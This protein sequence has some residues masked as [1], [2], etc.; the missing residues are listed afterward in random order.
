MLLQ[1]AE[2]DVRK[3]TYVSP[4]RNNVAVGGVLVTSVICRCFLR[5]LPLR[6]MVL[7]YSSYAA[8]HTACF[9]STAVQVVGGT[10]P[11]FVVRQ[12]LDY[13]EVLCWLGALTTMLSRVTESSLSI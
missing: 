9:R 4:G 11:I 13:F 5:G 8:N 7:L 12:V 10:G 3:R 1:P 6:I 2:R